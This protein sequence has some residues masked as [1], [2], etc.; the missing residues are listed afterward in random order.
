MSVITRHYLVNQS[1]VG[2]GRN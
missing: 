1:V 2:S